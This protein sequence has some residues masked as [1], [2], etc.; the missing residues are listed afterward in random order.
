MS[1]GLGGTGLV[2]DDLYLMS[3]HD[4]TGKPFLQP[5]PLGI[6]LAAAL[7]AE[8]ILGGS[9]SLRHDGTVAAGRTWPGDDLTRRIRDQVAAEHGPHPVREWLLF[10][11]Q[12]AA[13]DVARRLERAGYL[14]R[15]GGRFPWRPGRWVPA[16]PDWAFASLLRVRAALNP[17]RP[18]AA[19]QAALAGL[20]VASGLSFR[21]AECLSP[22]GR[23]V[24]DA[25]GYLG[26][27]LR[28]LITQTQAAVDSA[29]LSH[30][31]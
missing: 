12:T 2:A 18:F 28:E 20:A 3:H 19:D 7:L 15:A 30:R 11:A 23:S 13:G 21:L 31:T 14:T 1:G 5:R 17:S 29:L 24:E 8:L 9:I 22:A 6:G 27:D 10:G 25:V 26:P 16:D 4:V